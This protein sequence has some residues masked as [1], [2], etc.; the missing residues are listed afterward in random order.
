MIL[1]YLT[2]GICRAAAI[3]AKKGESGESESMLVVIVR[4]ARLSSKSSFLRTNGLKILRDG[5]GQREQFLARPFRSRV[6][7][8]AAAQ[9]RGDRD[10]PF[11]RRIRYERKRYSLRIS[12][13]FGSPLSLVKSSSLTMFQNR[14]PLLIV[15]SRETSPPMLCPTRT[16][17]LN[18]GELPF[19]VK[20]GS[21]LG[22][23]ISQFTSGIPKRL[24][25]RVGIK[26]KL[27]IA[28]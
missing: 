26:P 13:D 2:S 18:E 14:S 11:D 10:H 16:M 12:N 8:F 25:G 3:A 22:Q 19:G 27:V 6:G 20:L 28:A 23:V 4:I 9:G 21:R 7:E 24:A 17:W 1:L 5:I 15:C